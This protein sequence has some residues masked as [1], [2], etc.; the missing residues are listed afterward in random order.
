M[1]DVFVNILVFIIKFLYYLILGIA[2][3]SIPFILSG[4]FFFIVYLFKGKRLPK[5]TVPPMKIVNHNIL[6][7]L[8][9]LFPRRFVLDLF[10]RD[11]DAFPLN[12]LHLFCGE[13]GSGK[14]LAML[15]YALQLKRKYPLVNVSANFHVDFA[16]QKTESIDDIIFKNNGTLGQIQM[17]DEIQTWFNSLESKNFPLEMIQEI[18][19][20]RKQRKMILGTSQVFTRV[21]KAIREQVLYVYEPLTIFGCL[22][23][24][25]VY[26]PK[27]DES[28]SEVARR[29]VKMYFFV[30]NEELRNC[31]DTYEKIER[32]NKKGFKDL[33]QQ[34]TTHTS[35]NVSIQLP[36]KAK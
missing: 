15:H 16:D 33:T 27:L 25:R 4:L 36:I 21:A 1:T 7:R 18:C 12:G 6:V 26:K 23:I 2:A 34:V 32:L 13:Q 5:R 17:I 22:T 10:G 9:I 3:C 14:T 11:P 30:H 35:N 8:F 28:G 31:Y 24:V 19:Q 20:Q 29:R